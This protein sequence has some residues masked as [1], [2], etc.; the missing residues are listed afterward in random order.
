MEIPKNKNKKPYRT[1]QDSE[2]PNPNRHLTFLF[3]YKVILE[4]EKANLES[5]IYG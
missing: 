2:T 1:V 3:L 4:M 5:R